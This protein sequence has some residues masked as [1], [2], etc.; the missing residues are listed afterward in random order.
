MSLIESVKRLF[1]PITQ[2]EPGTYEYVSPPDDPRNYRLHL[3][4]EVDGSGILI[5]NG[6]TILH[7][8]QSAVEYAYHLIKNDSPD[9]TARKMVKRYSVSFDEARNDYINFLD[10]IQI[11]LETPDLDP[12]SFLDFDRKRPFTGQISAPY[13]L[14]CAITYLVPDS[15]SIDYAPLDRVSEELSTDDW[16]IIIDKAWNAGIP[17][18]VFTGGE[19][20]FRTDLARMLLK[21]EENGQ[22]TGLVTDGLRFADNNYLEEIL[23]TGLDYI[24]LIFRPDIQE[25]KV[26][27]MNLLGADIF[28]AVHLT[29]KEDNYEQIRSFIYEFTNIGVKAISISATSEELKQQTIELHQLIAESGLELIWNIAVPFSELHPI[30]FEVVTP[31]HYEKSKTWLYLEPDGDVCLSQNDPDVFGNILTDPWEKI[32]QN[33]KI[34]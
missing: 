33:L 12:I 17:H 16:L 6:S 26:A 14:D 32:W 7:L 8:N 27:L 28:V 30:A 1:S 4:I 22:I 34:L 9:E 20:T 10:R 25:S 23:V 13:R 3:R 15:D 5:V 2:L 19:P 11:L 31:F 24:L 18:L 21:A 29:L